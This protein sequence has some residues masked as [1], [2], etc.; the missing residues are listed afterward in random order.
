MT[1]TF[2]FVYVNN[3]GADQT[4]HL[5]SLISTFVIRCLNVKHSLISMS[6]ISGFW[7]ASPATS[8]LLISF[9]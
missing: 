9:Y 4:A 2:V 6:E 3:K 8:S 7:L 1:K 5:P